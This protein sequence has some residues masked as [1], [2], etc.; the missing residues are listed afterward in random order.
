MRVVNS[1]AYAEIISNISLNFKAMVKQQDRMSTGKKYQSPSEDPY[2]ANT[3]MQM[4]SESTRIVQYQDNVDAAVNLVSDTETALRDIN[5]CIQSIKD[6]AIQGANGTLSLSERESICAEME[7]YKQQIVTNLNA[8]STGRYLFGGYNTKTAPVELSGSSILYNQNDIATMTAAQVSALT[9]ETVSFSVGKGIELDITMTALDVI[10]SGSGNLFATIDE[11]IGE[12]SQSDP[13]QAVLNSKMDEIDGHF[14]NVLV[15]VTQIG[16]K[17]KRLEMLTS[18]LTSA[19]TG[20]DE[21]ISKNEDVDIE[22]AII[23]YMMAEQA[24]NA[25]LSAGSKIVKESLLDYIG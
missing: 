21:L 19:K 14:N 15:K 16:G 22:E 9:S 8:N 4:R 11:L 18:Q 24:Y 23:Q 12:L 7:Q 20:L 17:E 6:L 10:G 25:S 5:E 2:S 13:D 3:A 1:S